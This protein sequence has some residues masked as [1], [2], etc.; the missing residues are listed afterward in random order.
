MVQR[1]PFDAQS[2]SAASRNRPLLDV[3]VAGMP[4]KNQLT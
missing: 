4:V 3:N 2:P 1:H